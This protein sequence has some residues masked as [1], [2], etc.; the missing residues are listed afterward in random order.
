MS[1]NRNVVVSIEVSSAPIVEN[2]RPLASN[3]I[4]RGVVRE[5]RERRRPDDPLA[6]LQQGVEPNVRRGPQLPRGL[7]GGDRVEQLQQLP[8][9]RR[10]RSQIAF[11]PSVFGRLMARDREGHGRAGRDEVGEQLELEGLDGRHGLVAVDQ[12]PRGREDLVGG[13]AAEHGLQRGREVDDERGVAHVAE[14]HD[15]RNPHALVEQRVVQREVS[16]D[17]LRP[18]LRPPRSDPFLEAIEDARDQGAT[19]IVFD[20]RQPRAETE[21]VLEVPQQRPG[22]HL[23]TKPAESSSEPRQDGAEIA[24]PPRVEERPVDRC[25]AGESFEHSHDVASGSR[26][27]DGAAEGLEPRVGSGLATYEGPRDRKIGVDGESVQG[28]R[29]LHVDHRGSLRRVRD[30]EDPTAACAVVDEKRLVPLARER[31]CESLYAEDLRRDRHCV[32]GRERRQGALDDRKRALGGS[33][34]HRR[35]LDSRTI[36]TAAPVEI[37]CRPR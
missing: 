25:R 7:L 15:P 4:H 22:G 3:E 16:V 31:A 34:V 35:S 37:G 26:A 29:G 5:G 11:A 13:S 33:C 28:R 12:R 19:G 2:E 18:E 24:E 17:H 23:V 21:H 36:S 30:L 1:Q 8:E 6:A 14:V 27:L 9:F 10:R 32:V 20:V